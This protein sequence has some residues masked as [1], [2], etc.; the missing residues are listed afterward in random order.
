MA[1]SSDNHQDHHLFHGE[2]S[3]TPGRNESWDEYV[4][5]RGNNRWELIIE[6]TDF[7]GSSETKPI[8]ET[9][10]TKAIVAWALDRDA[11]IEEDWAEAIDD[12]DDDDDD[13]DEDEDEDVQRQLG[14]RGERLREIAESVNATYCVSCLDGWIS[15]SWPPERAIRVLRITGVTR[16]GVWIRM[17]HSVYEVDTN[18]GPGFLYPPDAHRA[19]Q[20][21]LKSES[22]MSAGRIV[23]VSNALM[24][25][26]EA[27]R[28]RLEAL[29][30][31]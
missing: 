13:E 27:L 22:S 18:L 6:G 28:P 21:V 16:R 19:A 7:S 1:T 11:E 8:K 14:P 12:D 30:E 4:R 2:L 10:S 20:L 15:G 23:N 25:K 3:D 9:K 24:A 29:R 26:I 31:Q 17:Y 5:Y